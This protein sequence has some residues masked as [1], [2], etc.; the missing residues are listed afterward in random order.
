MHAANSDGVK[1]LLSD[2]VV[3]IF[4]NKYAFAALKDD[5]SVVTFG[6]PLYGGIA[7]TLKTSYSR[8]LFIYILQIVL[9]Q[10]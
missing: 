3:D 5:G 8:E 6:L 1:G 7:L 4:S 10:H 2:S 9:L